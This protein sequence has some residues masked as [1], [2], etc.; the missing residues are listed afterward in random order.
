MLKIALQKKSLKTPIPISLTGF[1]SSGVLL[2]RLKRLLLVLYY[3]PPWRYAKLAT[4][5]PCEEYENHRN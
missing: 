3:T 1:R 5:H 2:H 4:S